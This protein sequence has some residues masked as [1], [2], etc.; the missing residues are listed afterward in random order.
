MEFVLPL[1]LIIGA[2]SVAVATAI[3]LKRQEQ[4]YQTGSLAKVFG[5]TM[6]GHTACGTWN[7][8][9]VELRVADRG[10]EGTEFKFRVGGADA[11]FRITREPAR[12]FVRKPPPPGPYLPRALS[13]GYTEPD[14]IVTGDEAFDARI[15]AKGPVGIGVG[16]LDRETRRLVQSLDDLGAQVKEGWIELRAAVGPYDPAVDAAAWVRLMAELADALARRGRALPLDNLLDNFHAERDAEVRRVNLACLGAYYPDAPETLEASRS[17][18]TDPGSEWIQLQGA[19]NL[20]REGWPV[21]R[22]MADDEGRLDGVR[23]AALRALGLSIPSLEGEAMLTAYLDSKVPALA[24]SAVETLGD[25][26]R[27]SGAAARLDAWAFGR[28][29][30]AEARVAREAAA[31]V[32]ARLEGA[33]PGRLSIEESDEEGRLSRPEKGPQQ[34]S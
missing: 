9:P 11:R 24:L 23:A 5:L 18:L 17:A 2:A 6:N 21:L 8:R 29:E 13:A 20:R 1:A 10:K 4:H 12:L 19:V 34:G 7:G 30:K 25:A 16:I 14:D 26:G 27:T 32:R 22:A 31:K 33:E 3:Y 15:R 28:P